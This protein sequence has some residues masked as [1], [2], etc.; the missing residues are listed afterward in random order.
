MLFCLLSVFAWESS[1][2]WVPR[3]SLIHTQGQRSISW[4]F[5][6]GVIGCDI[7]NVEGTRAMH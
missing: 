5:V 7:S 1:A 2:I 3:F 4:G 6:N